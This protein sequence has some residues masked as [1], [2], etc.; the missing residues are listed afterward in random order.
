MHHLVFS[1]TTFALLDPIKTSLLC[2]L[3]VSA[4]CINPQQDSSK[5]NIQTE[6][7][8][9]AAE[10][11]VSSFSVQEQ[12]DV[13]VRTAVRLLL[14]HAPPKRSSTEKDTIIYEPRIASM[15]AEVLSHRLPA[16]DAEARDLLQLC[17]DVIQLGSVVIADACEALA[18]SRAQYH[19]V[20]GNLTREVYWL[21]RGIEIQTCWLPSDRQR[22]LG[23]ASRRNFDVLCEQ[24]ANDL[25]SMLSTAAITSFSNKGLSESEEK[26]M[27]SVLQSAEDVLDGIIQ[28]EVMASVLTGHVEANLLKYAVDIALADA[29]G[30]TVQVAADIVHCLEERCLSEDYGGVVS[31]LA[32]P[33]IYTDLLHIAFAILVKEDDESRGKPMELA[34][35]AFT[36]HGMHILMAQLTQVLSW[37]KQPSGARGEYFR[38]MRLAFCKALMRIMAVADEASATKEKCG[39]VTIDNELELMLSPCI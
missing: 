11:I 18:F 36:I 6:L 21:L 33:T 37:E 2:N 29:K 22:K 38:A 4:G 35:C 28:D 25:I 10:A 19:K 5:T 13:G 7:I 3:L 24:S 26:K 30:D 39:E 27:L 15:I 31:T 16:T 8:L 1:H 14:P 32:N 12:C 20:N 23:F 9:L 34:K 17:E